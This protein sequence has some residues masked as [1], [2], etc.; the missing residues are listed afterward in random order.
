MPLRFL[1]LKNPD[2]EE[3]GYLSTLRAQ[4]KYAIEITD[5][6][7]FRPQELNPGIHLILVHAV[8]A[9]EKALVFFGCL[10]DFPISTPVLAILPEHFEDGVLR[11]LS[12]VADDFLVYPLRTEELNLRIGRILG[13]WG[14]GREQLQATLENDL[15]LAQM[16]GQHP[17]FRAAV[18]QVTIFGASD[19]SI[20]ITGE[21]GTGKEVFAHA[22]HALGSAHKGPF[23]PVD[24]GALPE[25]LVENE[26]FG[27]R[28]G[29]FTDAHTEQKGLAAMAEG[30]TLFLDEIDSL[31]LASQAKLLRFLQERSYRALG[32]DHYTQANVRVIAAT[33]RP[34]EDAVRLKEF[35]SDLYFRLSVLRLKLPSLRER[36]GD[37]PLLARHF[38]QNEC[39]GQHK[40]FSAAALHLL[41]SHHWPGNVRELFNAIQRAVI[42]SPGQQILPEHISLNDEAVDPVK[43]G[44]ANQDLK[45]AKRQMIEQFERSYIEQLLARHQGNVT[46]AAREAGKERRAFGKLVKKY[47]I[48]DHTAGLGHF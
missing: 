38:L 3:P 22:I 26:L 28:R 18:Q 29:A 14:N 40:S 7:S 41:E 32:A 1:V 17:S 12:Q 42:C 37:I 27:H 15:V 31:S 10:R 43:S 4:T 24:C 25:H 33:N 34:I 20:L 39:S 8:S 48:H 6:A 13:R 19:A 47:G 9:E 21:T 11:E 35:R 44:S 23:I 16:V 5:W 46:R 2:K 45:T 30:G 36:P